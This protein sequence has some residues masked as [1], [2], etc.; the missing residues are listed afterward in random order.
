[1][2][3]T[4]L[5]PVFIDAR[6]DDLDHGKV[7]ISI[8]FRTSVH[9]CC[10][11]CGNEVWLPIRPNRWKLTYDGE[12]ISFCPSIGNWSFPCQS[13]YWIRDGRVDW[14]LAWST[15]QIADGRTKTLERD[16]GPSTDVAPRAKW[17]KRLLQAANPCRLRP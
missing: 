8:H 16:R 3:V 10:C 2:R 9:L 11:G 4:R 5:E 13:H 12:N 17:W 15:Q 7:Y 1:M 6:P 14:A